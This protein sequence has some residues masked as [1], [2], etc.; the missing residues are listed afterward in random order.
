MRTSKM[1]NNA[2]IRGPAAKRLFLAT[3]MVVL[4]LL[5]G[6]RS[7][8]AYNYVCTSTLL[9]STLP[10]KLVVSPTE[11]GRVVWSGTITGTM[12][13]CTNN[14]TDNDAYQTTYIATSTSGASLSAAPGLVLTVSGTPTLNV[15]SGPCT[16]FN[17][18]PAFSISG[19][20]YSWFN[21]NFPVGATCTYSVTF[22][23]TLT[24]NTSLGAISGNVGANLTS[25][26]GA[27]GGTAGWMWNTGP[28]NS[29]NTL[30]S[31]LSIASTSCTLS[32]SNVTVT[33]P[34]V[35]AG[36]LAG[37]GKTAGRTPFTLN[38][39]GCSNIG[40]GYSALALWSFTPAGGLSNVIS[41]SASS[42]AANVGIQI[43]DG[44]QSPVS[45]GVASTLAN[46]NAAGSY[47]T[48]YYAQYY[49]TGTAG[50]GH[51]TGL[52]LFNLEY[53]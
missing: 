31:S 30:S 26:R 16:Y 17:Y 12:N 52:A 27:A 49:A 19:G 9:T 46:I 53:Q 14:S 3:V 43:L 48:A 33:L 42:P 7:A 18:T 10:S 25:D 41:N 8:W 39:T 11:N 38:L 29:D 50:V 36:V 22:P 24:M 32:T 6:G 23:V 34:A 35:N 20:V 2:A 4:G 51:V 5:L 47:S 44:S 37:A 21:V 15:T 28:N 45:N 40:S 13:H 1:R